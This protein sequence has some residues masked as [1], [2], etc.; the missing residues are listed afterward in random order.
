MTPISIRQ[1]IDGGGTQFMELLQ[2]M[3]E[4]EDSSGCCSIERKREVAEL[5]NIRGAVL[6]YKYIHL[7]TCNLSNI[8]LN[9]TVL[10]DIKIPNERR[11]HTYDQRYYELEEAVAVERK[12]SNFNKLTWNFVDCVHWERLMFLFSCVLQLISTLLQIY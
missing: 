1:I 11:I 8:C 3:L 5:T 10:T 9:L 2:F 6:L 4:A 7:L 12:S